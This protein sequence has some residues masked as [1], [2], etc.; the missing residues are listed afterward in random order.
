MK[1][2]NQN[3]SGAQNWLEHDDWY[4]YKILSKVASLKKF[5]TCANYLLINL[6][7][8]FKRKIWG[9]F[10]NRIQNIK[11]FKRQF[12]SLTATYA[13]TGTESWKGRTIDYRMRTHTGIQ[14]NMYWAQEQGQALSSREN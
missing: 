9:Q 11:K 14:V 3:S 8:G 1:R 12:N 7:K 2:T 5:C 10:H 13:L 4:I 6:L